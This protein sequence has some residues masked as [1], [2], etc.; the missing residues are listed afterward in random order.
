[1]SFERIV[2]KMIFVRAAEAA[3]RSMYTH[4]ASAAIPRLLNKAIE[5]GAGFAS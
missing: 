4:V 2:S 5:F 1:M 3:L